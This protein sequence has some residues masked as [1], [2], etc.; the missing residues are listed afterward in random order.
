[1]QTVRGHAGG[2]GAF[3]TH[4]ARLLRD[5]GEDV[6]II[7]VSASTSAVSIDREWKE[8]YTAWGIDVLEVHTPP[9]AADRWREAWPARLSEELSPHL[10]RFDVV[11]L[12]D[13]A[14]AG[15]RAI[16]E[17]RFS[18]RRAPVFVTVLHG[19]SRWVRFGNRQLPA[20]PDDVQIEYVERYSAEHSDHVVAPSRYLAGWLKNDGWRFRREPEVLG[21]PYFGERAREG[22]S[23]AADARVI[24]RLVFF[25]RLEIRKGFEIFSEA[26]RMLC[27]GDPVALS[28]VEEIILLGQE[29]EP[30][31]VAALRRLLAVTGVAVVHLPNL[32]TGSAVSYLAAHAST[33]LVVI[34]SPFENFPYAV[35]EALSIQGLNVICS[36]GGGIP[37]VVG[38]AGEGQLFEPVAPALAAMIA[39]RLSHPMQAEELAVYDS[40]AANARWLA[41][42]RD[43]CAGRSSVEAGGSRRPSVDVCIP[44]YNKG[45]YLR[46]LLVALAGQSEKNFGVIAIDDGST[47]A[48]SRAEFDAAAGEY[49]RRGWQFVRQANAFVDAARDCAAQMSRADYLLFLDADDVPTPNAVERLLDAAG[50]SGVDCLLSGG[51]L[52]DAEGAPDRSG[53][54]Y[55]PLGPDMLGGLVDPMVLGLPMIL[56]RRAAFEKVG[57]YRE[58]RGAGHEDWEFQIRLLQAGCESDVLPEYLLHFRRSADGLTNTGEVFPA[59]QRLTGAY[60]AALREVGMAGLAAVLFHLDRHCEELQEKLR[61]N[62]PLSLR[63]RLH[64]QQGVRR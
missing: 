24:R 60:D 38:S 54:A 26:L 10:F 25:G 18:S 27:D 37:E 63:M 29:R 46:E 23:A 6:S 28:A 17:R 34:P 32:D 58:C 64:E 33:A 40:A 57:G 47:D 62:V 49:A 52:L 41:F 50:R 21:L 31:S 8:R 59:Q 44:Y 12:Q 56:V 61:R 19:P 42:H 36:R 22:G 16:R 3:V 48:L 51:W 15:F 35:M 13:W 30:G 39:E 43:V 2:V 11:Y 45:R 5:A 53:V 55:M 9:A 14:N 1:M 7:F 4:F 20:I